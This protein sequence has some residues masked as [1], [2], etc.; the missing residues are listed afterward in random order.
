MRLDDLLADSLILFSLEGTDPDKNIFKTEKEIKAGV[1]K[2]LKFDPRLIDEKISERLE[3]LS[4]K[5]RKIT[6]HTK[7]NAFCL[8][9]ETRVEIAERNLKDEQLYSNFYQQ[10]QDTMPQKTRSQ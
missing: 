7:V 9:Y 6:Y 2:Y 1:E 10:T 8:P 4:T 3:V 5:P